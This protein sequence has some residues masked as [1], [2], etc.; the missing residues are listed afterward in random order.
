M[1]KKKM[2]ILDMIEEYI[3]VLCLVIMTVLTFANV[4]SRYVFHASLS[5]SEEITTYLFILLSLL[6]TA[7]AAKRRAHLGLSIL[8]D[9]VSPKAKKYMLVFGFALSAVLSLLLLYY[10]IQMVISEYNFGQ[11]TAS[12]QWPE[13]V[14]GCFVPFGA[15]FMTIRFA[16]AAV[17]EA[18]APLGENKNAMDSEI[19][20]SAEAAIETAT[21]I[22]EKAKAA[23]KE[24]EAKVEAAMKAAEEAKK[25][26]EEARQM[27]RDL[28]DVIES[29]EGEDK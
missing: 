5:F 9:K 16:Q 14:Y 11:V 29:K 27:L 8:T 23:Q 18:K 13:W 19:E 1:E 28:K 20:N 17:E 15:I 6:G 12:M 10:G 7:I 2:T 3:S 22:K 4:V 25:E 21:D 24:A 26:V